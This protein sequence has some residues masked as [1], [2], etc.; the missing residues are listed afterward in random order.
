LT[1][2]DES[3]DILE[4]GCLKKIHSFEGLKKL[5]E[6]REKSVK[7]AKNTKIQRISFVNL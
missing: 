3:L 1:E 4:I 6:Y 5:W 2:F 7:D